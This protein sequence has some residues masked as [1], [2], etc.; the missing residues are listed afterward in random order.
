MGN[1]VRVAN[2]TQ[3]TGSEGALRQ[4]ARETSFTGRDKR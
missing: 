1:R 2:V 4:T 3:R